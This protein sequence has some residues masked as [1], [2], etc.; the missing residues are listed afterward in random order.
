MIRAINNKTLYIY[1]ILVGIFSQFAHGSSLSFKEISKP[2]DIRH[3]QVNDDISL[4]IYQPSG[5]HPN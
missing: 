5:V 1:V 2:S 3:I 4:D